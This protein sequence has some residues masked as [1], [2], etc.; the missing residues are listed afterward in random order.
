MPDF[1]HRKF[2]IFDFDGT[3]IDSNDDVAAALVHT[4]TEVGGV[5]PDNIDYATLQSFLGKGLAETFGAFLPSDRHNLIPQLITAFR[6]YY[7]ENCVNKTALFPGAQA[8]LQK[9]RTAGKC[10]AIAT[11]KYQPNTMLIADKLG[12]SPY[13]DFIQGTEP[14]EWPLK[15][16]PFILNLL[17][18]KAGCRPDESLMLGDT[19]N[20]VLCAQ[21]AGIPVV[22]VSWGAWSAERLLALEPQALVNNFDELAGL[23]L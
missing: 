14:G 10:T 1:K 16:D 2:I 13:F 4:L 9:L 5:L 15:P 20:D 8:L 23:L 3:L 7:R 22:A 17:M 11:T 18:Q 12:L 6:E 21:R 19:D